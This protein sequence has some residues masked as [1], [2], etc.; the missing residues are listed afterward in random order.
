MMKMVVQA[1]VEGSPKSCCWTSWS[2]L[3]QYLVAA[4]HGADL[5]VDVAGIPVHV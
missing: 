2:Q 5:D 1:A 3:G 4:R